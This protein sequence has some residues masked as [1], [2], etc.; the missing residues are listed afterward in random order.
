MCPRKCGINR[1][2]P[3]LGF[4]RV[5]KEYLVS[6]T[7]KHMWE[8]PPISGKNGSGTIFFGGC[9]LGC[10]Y[11]Q[12]RAISR[13]QKG[14]LMDEQ[15]LTEKIW[16][17]CELGAH[18]VNFVTPTHYT[19][20][21]AKLLEK[22]KHRLPVPVVWNTGGYENTDALRTLDGLVDIY[23]PDFKY[24]SPALAKKYS[25]AEDYPEIVQKAIAE[26][27]R[28]RG[29]VLFDGNGML[30]SGVMVRHLVLPSHRADSIE[31]LR[32]LA[33]LVPVRDI[34]LSLMSQYTPDFVDKDAYPELKRRVTS[35]E[36]QSVLSVAETLGFEG[37]FQGRGSAT[38]DYT[39]DF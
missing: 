17:L 11:C 3:T 37:Y 25:H 6:R 34:R 12:N 38:S 19:L 2:E 10:V 22:I 13:G 7:A 30:K 4:C 24:H 9:N 5:P 16:E 29:A 28:Q 39:P 27:H 26:M 15:E 21:L 8:E 20:P 1:N 32:T 18:N 36:Y 33:Q 31:V 23:L 14:Q 35:F